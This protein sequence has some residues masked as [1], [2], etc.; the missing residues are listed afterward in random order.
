M[1]TYIQIH[2]YIHKYIHTV[3][4]DGLRGPVDCIFVSVGESQSLSED[5]QR[6]MAAIPGARL[7]LYVCMYV[8]MYV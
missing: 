6:K 3:E 1:H 4:E 2:T 7:I 8:C 5:S